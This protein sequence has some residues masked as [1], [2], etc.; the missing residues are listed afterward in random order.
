MNEHHGP[1]LVVSQDGSGTHRALVAAVADA[2]P[3]A[4]IRLSS[5]THTLKRSLLIQKSLA[6]IG[7][8]MDLTE[9][10]CERGDYVL[11][12]E[13]RGLFTMRNLAVRWAGPQGRACDVA[14]V[15]GGEL[16]VEDCRFSGGTSREE[17]HGAG[18]EIKGKARGT[19]T[20][21][22]VHDNGYGL[23]VGEE[24]E[25]LLEANTCRNNKVGGIAYFGSATGRA[26]RN[27]STGNG[28]YGVFVTVKAHPTLEENTCRDNQFTGIA[29]FD[30]TGGVARNNTC[31]A[32]GLSG[33]VV[34]QQAR[35]ELD[36]NTA[37]EH[38]TVGII[39][40]GEATGTAH[41]NTCVDNGR[42]GIWLGD[43]SRPK[44]EKN[45]CERNPEGGVYVTADAWP[46]LVDFPGWDQVRRPR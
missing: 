22:Q 1:A 45:T 12:Y 5:G 11:R 38:R 44:L 43:R 9:I 8:G 15:F 24:A 25:A 2:E 30:Q 46:R 29:Y 36:G 35:P 17:M 39:Y 41:H 20:R 23:V 31:I 18:L 6:L 14:G 16:L 32:N 7:E 10:V 13:G 33:F 34:H 21:C 42:Y 19:V 37:N 28:Y 26:V 27:V 3:G 40:A 4:T